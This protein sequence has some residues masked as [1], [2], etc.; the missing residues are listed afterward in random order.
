MGVITSLDDESD[1][2][3]PTE[4]EEVS[5]DSDSDEDETNTNDS[6]EVIRAKAKYQKT[7]ED[8]AKIKRL[9]K[10]ALSRLKAI[11]NGVL[12]AYVATPEEVELDRWFVMTNRTEASKQTD[13][14]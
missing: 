2:E 5:S 13:Q 14:S 9:Y 6:E 7:K 10:L 8:L 1:Q 11:E 4:E 3:Q 12:S